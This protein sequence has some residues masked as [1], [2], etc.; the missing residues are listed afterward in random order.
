[1][2]Q[3]RMVTMS[4]GPSQEGQRCDPEHQSHNS[5]AKTCSMEMVALLCYAG[6]VIFTAMLWGLLTC[7]SLAGGCWESQGTKGREQSSCT[8]SEELGHVHF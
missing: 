2:P 7:L 4:F 8:L 3:S 6:G 1:M 5:C